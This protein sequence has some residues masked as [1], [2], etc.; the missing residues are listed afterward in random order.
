MGASL[1]ASSV[2]MMDV[3]GFFT[4]LAVS[5]KLH[6][7]GIKLPSIQSMFLGLFWSSLSKS[8]WFSHAVISWNVD[9]Q[10]LASHRDVSSTTEAVQREREDAT[11]I[12]VCPEIK[13]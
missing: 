12:T 4:S 11:E 2:I 6:T 10:N 8:H 3:F 9:Y 5:L 1:K 13:K 7:D